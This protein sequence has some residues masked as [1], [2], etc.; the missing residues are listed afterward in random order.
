[1]ASLPISNQNCR[2]SQLPKV[3]SQ[4]IVAIARSSA[5]FLHSSGS[6]TSPGRKGLPT[7]PKIQ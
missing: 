5:W 6:L 7:S 4:P 1:V 2:F 3:S